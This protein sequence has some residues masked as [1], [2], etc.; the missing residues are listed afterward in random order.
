[1]VHKC[2]ILSRLAKESFGPTRKARIPTYLMDKINGRK[3]AC[4]LDTGSE[5]SVIP[6]SLVDSDQ[7]RPK[8]RQLH[9]ANC[10]KIPILGVATV[11]FVTDM[12]Q[13]TVDVLVRIEVHL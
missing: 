6:A 1:M 8:V 2:H 5:V 3:L 4:L 13:S 11:S 9:A 12:Y 7:V 10:T